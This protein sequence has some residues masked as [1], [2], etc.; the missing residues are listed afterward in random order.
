LKK[1]IYD[2]FKNNYLNTN[3]A[4]GLKNLLKVAKI[5]ILFIIRKDHMKQADRQTS[6]QIDRPIKLY[7]FINPA[8]K[9]T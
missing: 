5:A 6:R 3:F 2:I 9:A 1:N 4:K 8:D 7:Q